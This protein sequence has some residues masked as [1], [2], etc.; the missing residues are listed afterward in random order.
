MLPALYAA[1]PR[2]LLE[3]ALRW[4]AIM[5]AVVLWL[6]RE[7]SLSLNPIVLVLLEMVSGW[8]GFLISESRP[9]G[10]LGRALL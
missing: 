7:L 2:S 1:N 10:S 6:C 8:R 5:V 9:S 4:V 3:N